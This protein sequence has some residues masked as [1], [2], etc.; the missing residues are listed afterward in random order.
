MVALFVGV[1]CSLKHMRVILILLLT[2]ALVR[3][4]EPKR[5]AGLSVYM[6][7]ERVAALSG[8]N[9]GFVATDPESHQPGECIIEPR[10]LIT[11]FEQL[12]N[13]I[14]R[15]GIWIVTTDPDAYSES[16]H[17]R[18]K[19]LVALCSQKSIAVY[20]CRAADLP[21]GWQPAK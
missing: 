5:E 7:P 14:Q 1:H 11:Y 10:K 20:T 17:R 13:E 9:G 21:S 4:V 19:D 16:E 12:S 8:K 2:V 6:L 15:N 18:L 3:G